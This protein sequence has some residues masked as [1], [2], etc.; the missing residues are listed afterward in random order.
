MGYF[1]SY[2]LNCEHFVLKVVLINMKKREC[3]TKPEGSL[4]MV[5]NCQGYRS[6]KT[7]LRAQ[8]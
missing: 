8:I 4:G 1:L 3:L 5:P 7:V 2:I 6:L